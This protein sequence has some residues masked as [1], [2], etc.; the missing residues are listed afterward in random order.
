[1]QDFVDMP[2]YSSKCLVSSTSGSYSLETSIFSVST[3][4]GSSLK[5]ITIFENWWKSDPLFNIVVP[6]TLKNRYHILHNICLLITH[7]PFFIDLT[8]SPQD[9]VYFR[10]ILRQSDITVSAHV[11]QGNHELTTYNNNKNLVFSAKFKSSI[12]IFC[13]F[14]LH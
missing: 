6:F 9:E 11:G 13:P 4:I 5:S 1:M 14:Y 2:E 3:S 7:P 12:W 10:N 8:M